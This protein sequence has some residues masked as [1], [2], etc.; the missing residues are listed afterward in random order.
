[1]DDLDERLRAAAFAYL[2]SI[3]AASGGLV[4]RQQL[5]AFEFEGTRVPLIESMRGIRKPAGL[6][7]AISILT[8]YTPDPNAR[9]YDDEIGPDGYLR[10][11]WQGSDPDQYDNRGLQ[12]A[13]KRRLPLMYF[14]GV[15]AGTY[16]AF[17]PVTLVAEE[18]EHQ[19]FVV[20]L[21]HDLAVGWSP[22]LMAEPHAPARRYAEHVAK[23]R[24]HQRVFSQRVLFAYDQRCALCRLGHRPLL[25][26]AHIV[27]DA[28][29]GE[30][31]VPNG[32]A[33]C[34]IHHRAFDANI[35]GVT[36]R[37][38][39]EI[40]RDVLHEHD[41]PTL[42]HALQGLHGGRLTLPRRRK[43]QPRP[44]L[45]EERYEEFRAAS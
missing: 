25:D 20:A 11:K 6:E 30:P 32:I 22:D 44:D 4:T 8:T 1:V 23:V 33:M 5:E 38:A 21:D 19:Q 7:A 39:I 37:Y 35:L 13:M 34:A 43:E 17:Y 26:A 9:P 27:S 3:T 24:L 41:G 15:A 10:Y 45:L 16:Q 28:K 14:I 42:Q 36:P 31:I 40:R 18:P 2:E 29:G 12:V